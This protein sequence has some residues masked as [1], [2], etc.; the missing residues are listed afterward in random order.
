MQATSP[1]KKVE[2]SRGLDVR[3][4]RSPEVDLPVY[5]EVGQIQ[6]NMR[7]VWVCLYK[8]TYL[9]TREPVS[10][11][12]LPRSRTEIRTF[13]CCPSSSPHTLLRNQ[14]CQQRR[15]LSAGQSRLLQSRM[16]AQQQQK[17]RPKLPSKL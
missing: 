11:L 12:P 5:Q 4:V 2:S 1:P 9:A 14:R 6:A 8:C 7:T 17:P 13:F 3:H 15:L 16:F 10:K